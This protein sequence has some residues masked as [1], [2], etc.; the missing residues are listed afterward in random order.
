MTD[1]AWVMAI[2]VKPW[3]FSQR[4]LTVRPSPVT[5]TR[6]SSRIGSTSLPNCWSEM[7]PGSVSRRWMARPTPINTSTAEIFSALKDR[8]AATESTENSW[9]FTPRT[10]T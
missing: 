9:T 1:A 4:A 10:M 8:N 3:P 7:V 5:A 6:N 2:K